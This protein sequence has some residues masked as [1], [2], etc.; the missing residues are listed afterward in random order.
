MIIKARKYF[1]ASSALRLKRDT[2]GQAPSCN[3]FDL[4]HTL[5]CRA[6]GARWR[7]NQC[8]SDIGERNRYRLPIGPVL[9]STLAVRARICAHCSYLLALTT[10]LESRTRPFASPSNYASPFYRR[11]L[12]RAPSAPLW[13]RVLGRQAGAA[14]AAAPECACTCPVRPAPVRARCD[15]ASA[16]AQRLLIG[17]ITHPSVA[18]GAISPPRQRVRSVHCEA[19][20]L[21]LAIIQCA[22]RDP[23]RA[24]FPP[25]A[26]AAKGSLYNCTRLIDMSR[27]A[28]HQE[29]QRGPTQRPSS[30]LL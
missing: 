17:G 18:G 5:F 11:S 6:Q 21:V 29:Y 13:G 9:V 28:T 19:S 8:T 15:S 1:S 4:T 25:A 14:R 3:T 26:R 7:S 30:V 23:G 16:A 24:C 10:S 22:P 2:T 27:V 12:P 20:L